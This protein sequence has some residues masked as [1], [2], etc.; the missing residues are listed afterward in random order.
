MLCRLTTHIVKPS[1]QRLHTDSDDY[2]TSFYSGMIWCLRKEEK[3]LFYKLID[4]GIFCQHYKCMELSDYSS[5]LDMNVARTV[6]ASLSMPRRLKELCRL[7]I[8]YSMYSN[9]VSSG[10]ISDIYVIIVILELCS[11]PLCWGHNSE[12]LWIIYYTFNKLHR[13]IQTI[14]ASIWH[15]FCFSLY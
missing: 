12:Y 7:V 9:K 8:R 13:S 2:S 15:F 14:Y 4:S 11:P 10:Y 3:L 5:N 1:L 6:R